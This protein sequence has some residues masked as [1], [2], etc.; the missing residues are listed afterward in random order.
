[1][2]P[3]SKRGGN[4]SRAAQAAFEELRA[5]LP[6]IRPLGTYSVSPSEEIRAI[7]RPVLQPPPG[8]TRHRVAVGTRLEALKRDL[9]APPRNL[10]DSRVP[11]P[12]TF[13]EADRIAGL[14]RTPCVEQK[15]A[16][17]AAI[18]HGGHGGRNG[19][20]VYANVTRC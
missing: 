5:I 4:S 1:V 15:E 8:F 20:T 11:P 9:G 7:M 10:D 12:V 16:R 18:I 3:S 17:R 13:A 6:G 2:K 14:P 19:A